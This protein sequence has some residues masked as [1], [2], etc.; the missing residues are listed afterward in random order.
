MVDSIRQSAARNLRARL[1]WYFKPEIPKLLVLFSLDLTRASC[2][3]TD[4]IVIRSAVFV[5][6]P[7]SP[8]VMHAV[9]FA[10]AAMGFVHATM[11]YLGH[12]DVDE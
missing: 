4:I 5:E 8:V 9:H 10:H 2:T 7:S 12:Q 3:G 11:E 1:A 6:P